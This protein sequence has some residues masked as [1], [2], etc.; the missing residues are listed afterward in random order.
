MNISLSDDDRNKK[1]SS[2]ACERNE[3]DGFLSKREEDKLS[4][5]KKLCCRENPGQ[6]LA[7]T[8]ER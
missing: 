7:K 6:V 2:K 8:V 3:E 5:L 1:R 4:F